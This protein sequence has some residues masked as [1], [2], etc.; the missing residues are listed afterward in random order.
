MIPS[1]FVAA[2]PWLD[3]AD[4][5]HHGPQILWLTHL[6]QALLTTDH[7]TFKL[8][9]MTMIGLEAISVALVTLIWLC[10]AQ[11][12][13]PGNSILKFVGIPQA[14]VL[15][16]TPPGHAGPWE[17]SRCSENASVCACSPRENEAF[18]LFNHV[19]PSNTHQAIH[20]TNLRGWS[21]LCWLYLFPHY[22][23]VQSDPA[24]R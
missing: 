3:H 18:T 10:A 6:Y 13:K 9:V 2:K 12:A 1:R 21:A 5:R 11:Q 19:N 14:E 22:T 16:S 23:S 15:F 24:V 20:W 17:I 8:C 7:L 4:R